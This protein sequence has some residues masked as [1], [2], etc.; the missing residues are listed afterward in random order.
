MNLSLVTLVYADPKPKKEYIRK[1]KG[2]AH[3][4]HRPSSPIV[5]KLYPNRNRMT[6]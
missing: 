4:Q 6:K 2:G 1:G 3:K 5:D